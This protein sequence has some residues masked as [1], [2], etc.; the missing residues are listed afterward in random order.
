MNR[1]S[2]LNLRKDSRLLSNTLLKLALP[3][4]MLRLFM[5]AAVLL[6]WYWLC[7][8]T[9]KQGAG[10][11]YNGFEAFGPQVVDFLTRVN[12]Y[13]WWVVVVIISL[14]F[15]AGFR[16]WMHQSLARGRAAIVP[17]GVVREL[18]TNLSPEVLDV[19]RW[20]WKD[21][22]QPITVGTLQTTL[23]QVRSG[24]VRK[25]ALARAQLA[26]LELAL[27]SESDTQSPPTD[28]SGYREPTMVA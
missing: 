19:L 23:K 25:M 24:R 16:S 21:P 13:I 15:L 5:F 4:I 1:S 26:E 20:V 22:G 2:T 27:S 18:C 11:K 14:C 12:P 28:S 17:L 7:S 3:R 10:V 6:S 8:F 9:I